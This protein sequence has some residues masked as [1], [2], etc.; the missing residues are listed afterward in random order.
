MRTK[1]ELEIARRFRFKTGER[2]I[3]DKN[4]CGPTPVVVLA[5]IAQPYQSRW[6]DGRLTWEP[7]IYR[8]QE[9]NGETY[10]A[11]D[12]DLTRGK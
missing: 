7:A 10:P 12:S 9:E 1:R 3:L 5:I 11:A 2:V 6:C 8:V 4:K